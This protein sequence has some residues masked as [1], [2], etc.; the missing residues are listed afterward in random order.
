MTD[1]TNTFLREGNELTRI[2]DSQGAF[3]EVIRKELRALRIGVD[4]RVEAY[5][6]ARLE[7]AS[8]DPRFNG[9]A[10]SIT[11][12]RTPVASVVGLLQA[13]ESAPVIAADYGLTTDEVA[14]IE[15]DLDWAQA[16]A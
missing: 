9:G 16:A 2:Q 10:L 6:P 7:I 15:S 13:G 8:V 5:T 4:G 3:F 12:T 14:R 1:L 11:R